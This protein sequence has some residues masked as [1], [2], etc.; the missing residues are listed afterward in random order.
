MSNSLHSVLWS[1]PTSPTRKKKKP[2]QSINQSDPSSK[3]YDI[4]FHVNCCEN[5]CCQTVKNFLPHTW[6]IPTPPPPYPAAE[7]A[8]PNPA[9]PVEGEGGQE[10]R[11]PWNGGENKA[12][13]ATPVNSWYEIT[14]E[15]KRGQREVVCTISDVQFFY[16]ICFVVLSE[17]WVIP[18]KCKRTG[19]QQ[20]F[21][22][23][24]T[25]SNWRMFN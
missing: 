11:R 13:T 1:S 9:P 14:Q 24:S 17:S 6:A 7:T 23:W 16:F 21:P 10:P 4:Y 8:A 19:E 25:V 2:N 18:K 12:P 5:G 20:G 15:K 22:V 3:T